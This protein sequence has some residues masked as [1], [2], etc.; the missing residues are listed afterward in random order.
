MQPKNRIIRAY[1]WFIVQLRIRKK[2][3]SDSILLG[4]SG[5]KLL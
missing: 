4:I 3:D 2:P 1:G 5:G